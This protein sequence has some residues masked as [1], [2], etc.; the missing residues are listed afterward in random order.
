[1][2]LTQ[3]T[4]ILLI[5]DINHQYFPYCGSIGSSGLSDTYEFSCAPIS[6]DKLKEL[7]FVIMGHNASTG[8]LWSAS[9]RVTILH[10]CS[11]G[12]STS[13]IY[14]YILLLIAKGR[15]G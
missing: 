1:M 7:E 14:V 9:V 2:T 3:I 10:Q 4:I 12:N 13:I 11:E 5:N 6:F 15:P 8:D